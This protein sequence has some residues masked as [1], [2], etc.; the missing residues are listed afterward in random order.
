LSLDQCP[1][2]SPERALLQAVVTFAPD[3]VP[4]SWVY[5]AASVRPDDAVRKRALATLEGL[6]LLKVDREAATLSMHRL[7]HRRARQRCARFRLA[8]WAMVRCVTSWLAG[9]V[10]RT[11]EQM[12]EIDVRRAH[13]A[14][15]LLAAEREGLDEGWFQLAD[16]LARHLRYRGWYE[17]SLAL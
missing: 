11:R 10:G 5:D 16:G 13:V 15:A 7:V 4:L 6:G 1:P 3:A 17:A 2:T 14:E 8:A 12:E 9:T